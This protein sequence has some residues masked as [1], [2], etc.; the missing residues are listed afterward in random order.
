MSIKSKHFES[1]KR[2]KMSQTIK[3]AMSKLLPICFV[4]VFISSLVC[5]VANDMY[6]FVKKDN[7]VNISIYKSL[8]LDEMTDL[9]SNRGVINNP[10]VFKL[11]VKLKEK[12]SDIED[13]TGDATFNSSMSYRE[14]LSVFS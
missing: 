5:S 3:R 11:Y 12:S 10:D 4:S 7:E 1:E 9:L 6:A 13:F 8:S 2:L 14:I